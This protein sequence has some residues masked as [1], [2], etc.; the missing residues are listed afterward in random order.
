ML[1]GKSRM[2]SAESIALGSLGEAATLSFDEKTALIDTLV[3]AADKRVPSSQPYR[4][5]P[6]MRRSKLAR[7]SQTRG[8]SGLMILPPMSIKA[9]GRR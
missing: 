2:A 1:S 4:R 6:P 5:F 7:A 3:A 8:A 9:T